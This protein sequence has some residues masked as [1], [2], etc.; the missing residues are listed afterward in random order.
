ML[1][2][3]LSDSKQPHPLT[4]AQLRNPG[5]R[6]SDSEPGSPDKGASVLCVPRASLGRL[7]IFKGRSNISTIKYAILILTGTLFIC[8]IPSFE[9]KK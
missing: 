8:S 6:A 9:G 4:P 7:G 3:H 1:E 5:F 2:Y